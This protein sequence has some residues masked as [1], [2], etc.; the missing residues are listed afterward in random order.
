M[1]RMIFDN[2]D[3]SGAPSFVAFGGAI[4]IPLMTISSLNILEDP[5]G[6]KN[7]K[8]LY[9]NSLF[10]HEAHEKTRISFGFS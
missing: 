7:Y 4:A 6:D 9:W 10:I 3:S 2:G 8:G 1:K 5:L